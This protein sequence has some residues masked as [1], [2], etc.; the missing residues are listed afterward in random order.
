MFSTLKGMLVTLSTTLRKPVTAQYPK[1]HLPLQER[2]WGFPA[3]TWDGD[4]GEPYCVGCMVCVRMCPTQC[5]SGEMIDN[6]LHAEGKSTRRK[7]IGEFEINLGRCILCGICVEVCNF[8]AI[9]MS[10]EHEISHYQRNGRRT[11]LPLLLEMG[12]KFQRESNWLPP[13]KKKAAV[14]AAA[15]AAAAP[16]EAGAEGEA[17]TA[18][19]SSEKEAEA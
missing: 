12:K 18:E 16:A 15:K 17:A 10:H 2:Q 1:Q 3:L 8:D 5:M 9:E 19:E 7:I 13:T 6:P 4:V 14:A 11:D